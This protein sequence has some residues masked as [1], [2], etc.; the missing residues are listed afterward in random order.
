[1]RGDWCDDRLTPTHSSI[2]PAHPR[3]VGFFVFA[4]LLLTRSSASGDTPMDRNRIRHFL[5]DEPT[6]RTGDRPGA[7]DDL[8]Q[9]TGSSFASYPEMLLAELSGLERSHVANMY[10]QAFLAAESQV[11]Q[12]VIERL[13][14]SI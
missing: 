13:L 3:T 5:V 10:R 11:R 14:A 12:A 6:P 4:T 9:Q 7:H 1:M 2:H 8:R